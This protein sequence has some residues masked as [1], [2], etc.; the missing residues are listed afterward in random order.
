MSKSIDQVMLEIRAQKSYKEGSQALLDG[1]S[2]S[3]NPHPY[4]KEPISQFMQWRNGFL[5]TKTKMK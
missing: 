4:D 5:D 2:I 1:E 3:D